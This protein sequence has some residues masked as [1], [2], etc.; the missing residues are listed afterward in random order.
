MLKSLLA[1]ESWKMKCF[2]ALENTA[3]NVNRQRSLLGRLVHS[4]LKWTAPNH[5][6][7]GIK[8]AV[9]CRFNIPVLL[10][11]WTHCGPKAMIQIA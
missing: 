6:Y 2:A 4:A 11:V 1:V 3:V 10:P 8:L 9:V 7:Q 5:A